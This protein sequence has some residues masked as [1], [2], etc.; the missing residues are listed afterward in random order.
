[1]QVFIISS[2]FPIKKALDFTKN[3]IDQ[4][5]PQEVAD[6]LY[7]N[8]DLIIGKYYPDEGDYFE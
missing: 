3:I 5:I 7:E 1:M 6:D 4:D 8:T 2:N